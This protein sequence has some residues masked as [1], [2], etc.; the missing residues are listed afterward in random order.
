MNHKT[1]AKTVARKPTN[2]KSRASEPLPD[3]RSAAAALI[4]QRVTIYLFM[5]VSF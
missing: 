1:R 4:K 2:Q 5:T 3:I